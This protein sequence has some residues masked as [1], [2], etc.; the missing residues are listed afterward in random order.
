MNIGMMDDEANADGS[1]YAQLNRQAMDERED[2]QL[3]QIGD[4]EAPATEDN[5]AATD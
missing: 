5:E 1:L 2:V 3:D 4:M